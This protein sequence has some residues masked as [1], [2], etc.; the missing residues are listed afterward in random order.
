M[1]KWRSAYLEFRQ[2]KKKQNPSFLTE[3]GSLRRTGVL[4]W[5][6]FFFFELKIRANFPL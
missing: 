6:N 4:F 3:K 2:N 1:T 5:A